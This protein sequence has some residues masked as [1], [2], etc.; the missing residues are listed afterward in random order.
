MLLV[1][2]DRPWLA[3]ATA[4]LVAA[5][6]SLS[7]AETATEAID[8]AMGHPPDVVVI[9]PPIGDGS[10]LMLINQLTQLRERGA[11]GIVY[12]TDRE[13]E[14]TEHARLMRAGTND[15]FP[16]G[17]PP[18]ETA[19]R[20]AALLSEILAA[21]HLRAVIRGPLRLDLIAKDARVGGVSLGL[22]NVEF[23]ILE[24]LAL[25]AG[26]MLT[27]REI[28]TAV[29]A[30][31][32]SQAARSIDARIMGLCDKMGAARGLLEASRRNGYRL[33]FVAPV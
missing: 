33:R 26:R 9:A 18:N 22:N 5:T 25:A 31:R 17:L 30:R 11:L 23:R 6:R 15:W 16:R 7:T 24:A 2:G 10:P 19:A 13:R 32:G 29:G 8:H 20:I 3:S 21:P 27:Q 1:S 28:A 14:L 12:V 4:F